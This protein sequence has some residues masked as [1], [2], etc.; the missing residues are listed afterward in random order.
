M[1]VDCCWTKQAS[2]AR[3]LGEQRA[4]LEA[5]HRAALEGA[6]ARAAGRL[7]AALAERDAAAERRAPSAPFDVSPTP[8]GRYF[9]PTPGPAH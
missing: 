6:E 7:A 9:S 3:A 2:S 8:A 5:E 1:E 4:A